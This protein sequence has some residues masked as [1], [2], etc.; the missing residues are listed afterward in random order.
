MPQSD[1]GIPYPSGSAAPAGAADM[2]AMAGFLDV[3]TVL[4]A[5]DEA[6]RDAKW[7]DFPAPVLVASKDRPA[8]WL[9]VG[10]AGTSADWRT[11]WSD[12][13]WVTT[14]FSPTTANFSTTSAKV[15]A[16]GDTVFFRGEFVAAQDYN[17]YSD[18]TTQAGNIPGDPQITTLPGA[19]LPT[20]QLVAYAQ[21][22][23]GSFGV[24]LYTD[25]KLRLTDG[26]TGATLTTGTILF[27]CTSWVRG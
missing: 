20:E 16:V 17:C 10:N 15:R 3:H 27:V 14:G 9:K 7:G 25:G 12:T 23:F 6:D 24:R 5:T 26:P 13:G 11:V 2:M 18:A 22:S 19:Y 1:S 8:V 4:H 21:S